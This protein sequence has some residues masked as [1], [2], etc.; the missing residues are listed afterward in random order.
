MKK[1]KSTRRAGRKGSTNRR[2]I[3][4]KYVM[5]NGRRVLKEYHATKGWRKY[6]AV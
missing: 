6:R 2:I 3:I 5:E 4:S 1:I